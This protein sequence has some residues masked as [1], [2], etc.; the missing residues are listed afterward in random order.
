[1]ALTE[2]SE[3]RNKISSNAQSC[4]RCGN[5]LSENAATSQSATPE[6]KKRGFFFYAGSAVISI[7]VLFFG[8]AIVSGIAGS[9]SGGSP[10]SPSRAEVTA[11]TGRIIATCDIQVLGHKQAEGERLTRAESTAI[12]NCVDVTVAAYIE[13]VK[14][15]RK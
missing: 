2:C 14:A 13:G 10:S 15:G 4:P 7:V 6:V 11:V 3:C 1:M 5:L 12:V 8:S 9:A